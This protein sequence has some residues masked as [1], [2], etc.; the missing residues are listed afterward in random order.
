MKQRRSTKLYQWQIRCRDPKEKCAWCGDTG[1][2]CMLTVDHIVPAYL[3]REFEVDDYRVSYEMEENFQLMCKQ[4]N[5]F[6]GSHLELK[7]PAT[8]KILSDLLEQT[9]KRYGHTI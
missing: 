2:K 1:D 7:N 8:Y 4:C 6:K 3:L 5:R 9:K